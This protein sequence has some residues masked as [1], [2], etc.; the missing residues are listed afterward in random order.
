MMASPATSIVAA[1][2]TVS[3]HNPQKAT[4]SRHTIDEQFAQVQEKLARDRAELVRGSDDA[5]AL[6]QTELQE[7]QKLLS[8][9]ESAVQHL[10][11]EKKADLKSQLVCLVMACCAGEQVLCFVVL[12]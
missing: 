5:Q 11:T 7:T 9:L 8:S 1:S 4:G 2:A 3:L 10:M 12:P 6:R